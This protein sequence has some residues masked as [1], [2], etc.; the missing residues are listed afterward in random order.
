[1]FEDKEDDFELCSS[2]YESIISRSQKASPLATNF[3]EEERVVILVWY[4]MGVID[5]G[6]FH[7]LFESALPGDPYYYLTLEAYKQIGCDRAVEAF[8]QAL[9]LFP[10]R[11]PST[12]DHERI[13][14]YEKHAEHIRNRIDSRFWKEHDDIVKNLAK[15]IR[16]N[17]KK[18]GGLIC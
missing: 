17:F 9:R 8:E 18:L 1:M 7:Y 3:S 2:V 5:N 15:Y 11:K 13:Q 14:Q 4:A 6:G 12:D 16:A 10:N